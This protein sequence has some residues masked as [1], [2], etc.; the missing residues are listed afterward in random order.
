MCPHIWGYTFAQF[1][2]VFVK[3]SWTV[4]KEEAL[5]TVS[6][7]LSTERISSGELVY[8]YIWRL[9]VAGSLDSGGYG[10]LIQAH[11]HLVEEGIQVGDPLLELRAKQP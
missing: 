10:K 2:Q 1:R 6:S 9:A 8:P 5:S 7:L 3:K 4:H 11:F